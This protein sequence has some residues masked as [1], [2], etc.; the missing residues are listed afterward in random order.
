GLPPILAHGDRR[1]EPFFVG[2]QIPRSPRDSPG[3]I[4]S[5]WAP[6][7]GRVV[8]IVGAMLFVPPQVLAIRSATSSTAP[9]SPSALVQ[10]PTPA[11]VIREPMTPPVRPIWKAV[12]TSKLSSGQ[13]T[14]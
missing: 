10:P 12:S 1:L 2:N 4:S 5:A 8:N 7:P 14:S 13:L 3:Y 11:P 6:C 9:V